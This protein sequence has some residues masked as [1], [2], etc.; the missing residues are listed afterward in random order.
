[1]DATCQKN[2]VLIS[3]TH[4]LYWMHSIKVT[5]TDETI[6]LLVK[7]LEFSLVIVSED[8]PHVSFHPSECRPISR[9][10]EFRLESSTYI[11]DCDNDYLEVSIFANSLRPF[12]TID[13]HYR[14]SQAIV[15]V[16]LSPYKNFAIVNNFINNHAERFATGLGK[17][18]IRR[19]LIKS[20]EG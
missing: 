15:I 5:Q 2:E 14:P 11:E 12:D 6:C 3:K 13:R 20:I 16:C 7:F 9:F 17:L 19:Q 18:R 8:W 10:D 4:L 1:M